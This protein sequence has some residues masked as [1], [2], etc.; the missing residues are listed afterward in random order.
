MRIEAAPA[1]RDY[2]AYVRPLGYFQ[3][4]DLILQHSSERFF[5]N[6]AKR[7]LQLTN[8]GLWWAG[9][10]TS[11]PELAGANYLTGVLEC[12]STGVME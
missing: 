5:G 1:K 12:W 11:F 3:S 9:N 10:G 7:V 4:W 8:A 6:P 2:N